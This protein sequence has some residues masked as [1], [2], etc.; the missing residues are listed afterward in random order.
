PMK[1]S[2]ITGVKTAHG[3]AHGW[4]VGC[5]LT[6]RQM[7]D[8][9]ERKVMRKITKAAKLAER[10]GAR[11]VGLG[12]LTS[13]VGDA[14]VTV[15][16]NVN[17]AV[18]TGNSYT[19]ATALE[20]AREAA[21]L[22]GTDPADAEVAVVGATGSIGSVCA[23][24]LAREVRALNLVARQ[25]EKLDELARLIAGESGLF[26]RVSTDVSSALTGADI[27]VTVTS[28]VDTVIEPGYLKP[29]AVVCDVARP[30]DVSK[31]VAEARRDVLVIEGGVVE[32]PGQVEFNFN[33][34]F[35]RGTS[36]ACMAETMILAMEERYENFSLGRD[37]SLERV[38]EI[39]TLAK[40]HGFRLAGFR[41]FERAVTAEEIQRVQEEAYNK[42]SARSSR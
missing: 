39:S 23:R 38:E 7:F 30:R 36:Y 32:V 6:P 27:V 2:E 4:F 9:P 26:P 20:G 15:A 42:K 28:A 3:E 35:P 40:K 25:K 19:V 22:M 12:A 5:P 37:L 41:S 14:G 10:L 1:T 17:I 13:V 34:G 8:L 21:R 24:I 33:F 16:R 18:T 11:I 31:K 29:G